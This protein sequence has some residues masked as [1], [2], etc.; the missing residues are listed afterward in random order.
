VPKR[1]ESKCKA[2]RRAKREKGFKRTR[3][4]RQRGA[5]AAHKLAKQ[6]RKSKPHSH[7]TK[8]NTMGGLNLW[9]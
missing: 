1:G 3:K 8:A 2:V 6:G 4:T 7:K 5:R 9:F